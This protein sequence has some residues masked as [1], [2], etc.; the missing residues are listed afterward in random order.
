MSTHIDAALSYADQGIAVFPLQPRSKTPATA[1]GFKD[2]TRDPG[3]ITRWWARMPDANIGI[4]TGAVSGIVV[5]DVDDNPGAI[6]WFETTEGRETPDTLMG[7]T[8]GGGWHLVYKHPGQHIG[9][10]PLSKDVH[11]RADG[12]YIVAPPSIHPNGNAYRW[13]Y[14]TAEIAELPGW[15]LERL[16]KRAPSSD[17]RAVIERAPLHVAPRSGRQL[18]AA[19]QGVIDF[20]R[21]VTS[22]RNDALLWAAC[23]LFDHGLSRGEVEGVLVPIAI[24]LPG[25]HPHTE[26]E[27]LR[28][29]GSA[30]KQTRRPVEQRARMSHAPA[31]FEQRN[32]ARLR[33]LGVK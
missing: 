13:D 7:F 26:G 9:N 28:T 30:E 23:R 10:S 17:A 19:I 31:T 12:G 8:G 24:S 25:D 5:I 18:Y 27:A 6:Q 33:G 11:V 3:Q 1:H 2:A 20:L 15:L 21:S 16:T 29:V 32:R 22:N 14:P 4:A